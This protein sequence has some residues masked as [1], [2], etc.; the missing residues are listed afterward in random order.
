MLWYGWLSYT[1]Y[2]STSLAGIM[3][4]I[5][6]EHQTFLAPTVNNTPQLASVVMLWMVILNATSTKSSTAKHWIHLNTSWWNHE[7]Y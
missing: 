2:L 4:D 3:R 6:T 5:A 1:R 7:G